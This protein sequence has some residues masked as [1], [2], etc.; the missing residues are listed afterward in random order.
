MDGI[1]LIQGELF[2]DNRGT[3]A[4]LNNFHFDEIRRCYFLRH[5]DTSVQRGWNGHKFE[6]KWFYPIKGSFAIA[7]AR[8]SDMES[9]N[10]NPAY[11]VFK[12]S[13]T[14]SQILCVP[15]GHATCI[16]ALET[17][18]IL[19]V[20]SDKLLEGSKSDSYKFAIDKEICYE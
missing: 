3:I 12:L 8:L 13:E 11:S 4:S 14:N 10:A 2:T 19:M 16:K 6:K 17:D 9:G 18:S 5:P 15:G 7:V 1:S 20:G